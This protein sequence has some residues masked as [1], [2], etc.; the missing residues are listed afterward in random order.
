MNIKIIKKFDSV[1]FLNLLICIFITLSIW[2]IYLQTTR[3]NFTNYDDNHYI[4]ENL[5][6]Q[7][8]FT[9]EAIFRSFTVETAGN[10][11]PVTILSH[12]LD[13]HIYGSN[14][15]G[16]LFINI[17]L[18]TLNSILLFFLIKKITGYAWRGAFIAALFAIHPVHVESV[19][20]VS[21][22]KDLLSMFFWLLTI[23][24]YYFYINTLNTKTYLLVF[25]FLVLG[26]MTKPML[27]TLPFIL[28]LFDFWPFNRHKNYNTTISRILYE[29]IPLVFP[30][31]LSCILT[32]TYQKSGG[33]VKSFSTYPL[34]TRIENAIVSYAAYIGKMFWPF[35]L[36]VY[37]PYP[38]EPS[39]VKLVASLSLL[40]LITLFS[41]HNLKKRP[42]F[43]CGWFLYIGM[44]VPVIGIV[45]VGSQALADRYMYIPSI[46]FFIIIVFGYSELISNKRYHILLV[47]VSSVLAFTSFILLSHIQTGYWK[48]S[49]TLFKHALEVTKKNHLAHNNIG[50]A[51]KQSG[52]STE[53]I[54]HYKQSL[55]IKPGYV[56][57]I[58]N[59]GVELTETGKAKEA[60]E[61]FMLA[62]KLKPDFIDAHINLA[63]SLLGMGKIQAAVDQ[64]RS[65]LELTQTKP[66]IHII[67]GDALA[68]LG[69]EHDA[70]MQYKK[71]IYLN[72]NSTIAHNHFGAFLFKNKKMSSAL[73]H[74]KKA[75][76]IDPENKKL[77]ANY[78]TAL[79]SLALIHASKNEYQK[80]IRNFKKILMVHPDRQDVYYNIACMYA[81]LNEIDESVEW[82]KK[83]VEKGY[84]NWELMKIDRDLENIRET[85]GYIQFLNE[86]KAN[87]SIFE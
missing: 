5:L 22:R 62:I 15:G 19:A 38:G 12:M 3:H 26:L 72:P 32:L 79:N 58:N 75:L 77:Q 65:A 71:A 69:N 11:H 1:F 17:L 29:K 52:K 42:W 50:L 43:S 25:V 16:H 78:I 68:A 46:G 51:Y 4:T 10:W 7:K 53:A 40:I 85:P 70:L 80:A 41:L 66:E 2:I 37:Y 39:F 61:Y 27:V 44:L 33:A 31:I 57:A 47:T 63:S 86:H 9:L 28:L 74:F 84:D 24:S 13:Y 87:D 21:E 14:A 82:L 60:S 83:A 67:L 59:L 64:C 35:N 56:P 49:I 6:V 23:R 73:S 55:S 30:I 81:R 34:S 54:K 8:G 20:W 48:N 45:Q 36:S 18:H 76:T